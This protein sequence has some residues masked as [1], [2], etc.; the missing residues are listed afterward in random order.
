MV[1]LVT[2]ATSH[3]KDTKIRDRLLQV[4]I[5]LNFALFSGR[6]HLC[7]WQGFSQRHLLSPR[8][9][10]SWR[11][12]HTIPRITLNHAMEWKWLG[13]WA[14]IAATPVGIGKTCSLG[15]AWVSA[16]LM[17]W[18]VLYTYTCIPISGGQIPYITHHTPHVDNKWHFHSASYWHPDAFS[19]SRVSE[20]GYKRHFGKVVGVPTTG[21]WG[22]SKLCP[23]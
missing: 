8:N 7:V 16:T 1:T 17:S 23:L 22:L 11:K 9:I 13:N 5:L 12:A 20:D 14:R 19:M 10:T 18:T 2:I 3:L 4:I 6:E 21:K 15:Q